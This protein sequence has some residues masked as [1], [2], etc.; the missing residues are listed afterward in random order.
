[1]A[2][3]FGN[4]GG[5]MSFRSTNN[6]DDTIEHCHYRH[7]PG[8]WPRARFLVISPEGYH[9]VTCE[10]HL[11]TPFTGGYGKYTVIRATAWVH[12]PDE[13]REVLAEYEL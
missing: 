3:E 11:K 5:E 7:K 6:P 12:E 4:K 9:I 2:I 8:K 13:V 1:M 10:Y